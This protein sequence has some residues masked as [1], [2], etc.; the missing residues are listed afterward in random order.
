MISSTLPGFSRLG[1]SLFQ[2]VSRPPRPRRSPTHPPLPDQTS[3]KDPSRNSKSATSFLSCR[4]RR[5]LF[6][7]VAET[8]CSWTNHVGIVLDVSGQS[9]QLVAESTFPF[10][11]IS[12]MSRFVGRSEAGRV[13]VMR[14]RSDLTTGGPTGTDPRRRSRKASASFMTRA[15]ICIPPAVPVH[16]LYAKSS[17]KPPVFRWVKCK[18]W[19]TCDASTPPVDLRFWNIWLL[20]KTSLAT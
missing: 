17:P 8:T 4:R 11:K 2:S 7:K 5:C 6:E 13:A 15:L 12:A 14:L 10:S 19:R 16:V 3:L 1:S 20:R 9:T 18:I